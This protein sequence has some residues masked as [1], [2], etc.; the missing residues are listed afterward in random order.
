MVTQFLFLCST[1]SAVSVGLYLPM[2]HPH[3][4]TM[5]LRSACPGR[6]EASSKI[7]RRIT[8]IRHGCGI[9]GGVTCSLNQDPEIHVSWTSAKRHQIV[10]SPAPRGC[11]WTKLVLTRPLSA[12]GFFLPVSCFRSSAPFHARVSFCRSQHCPPLKSCCTQHVHERST[13]LS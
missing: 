12:S 8:R 7:W 10:Q 13:G 6:G 4:S 3:W 11:R 9:A 5:D 1:A 2:N